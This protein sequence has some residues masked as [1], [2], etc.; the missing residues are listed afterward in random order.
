MT[1]YTHTHTHT[2]GLKSYVNALQRQSQGRHTVKC[3]RVQLCRSVID[4][5]LGSSC[6]AAVWTIHLNNHPKLHT[7]TDLLPSLTVSSAAFHKA[8]SWLLVPTHHLAIHCA[9][10][11]LTEQFYDIMWLHWNNI[12]VLLAFCTTIIQFYYT[13]LNVTSAGRMSLWSN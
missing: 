11:W 10:K 13:D 5:W 1:H 6:W 2:D 4:C 3:T 7:V 8:T 9:D 12:N